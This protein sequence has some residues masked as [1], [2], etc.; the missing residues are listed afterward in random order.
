ML[1]K[2]ADAAALGTTAEVL[3]RQEARCTDLYTLTYRALEQSLPD[4][5]WRLTPV[6]I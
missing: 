3:F 2:A 4:S 5:D 6:M 1:T